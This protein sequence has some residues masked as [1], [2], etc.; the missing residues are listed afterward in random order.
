MRVKLVVISLLTLPLLAVVLVAVSAL[1]ELT[2]AVR[3]GTRQARVEA[4]LVAAMARDEL[5]RS[6]AE[7]QPGSAAARGGAL[8]L[9]EVLVEGP[10]LA[11]SVLSVAVVDTSGRAEAHSQASLAGSMIPPYPD[12]PDTRTFVQSLRLLSDLWQ[13]P[14]V[15]QVVVPLERG[16]RAFG[17][18]RVAISGTFVWDEVRAA[19]GRGLDAALVVITL[20]VIAG[21][22]LA[23]LT[24][25]RMRR[26]RAGVAA[27]RE[28]RFETGLPESA[29]DELGRV[30]RELNLLG[31]QLKW[32]RSR[33]G[34][35]DQ[36]R[37]LAHLGETAA[38]VAHELR[39]HLQTV[40]LEL[41]LLKRA[42]SMPAEEVARHVQRASMGVDSLGGA[43]RGF[44][45]VARVRPLAPRPVRVNE[46][47]RRIR[48]ELRPQAR[49]TGV[50]LELDID[51]AVPEVAADPEVLRQA[52]HNLVR[53]GLQA[54]CD[55]GGTI[56][57]RSSFSGGMI[58]I[59]VADDGPGIP[60]EAQ[61]HAF[62]LFYTTRR[63]GT[64][65][66]LSLVRQA[67][68]MHGGEVSIRSGNGDGT[69]VVLAFPQRPA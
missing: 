69:E 61:V 57:L 32:E 5:A 24:E 34:L 45:K 62:D 50:R 21:I 40:Q 16:G 51:P 2:S 54:L 63:D 14:R 48:E 42:E 20:A 29:A 10:A 66:G 9:H 12:L 59:A 58:R 15:Y 37:V 53:N 49:I 31:A 8:A 43:V 33:S 64:G 11:P 26:L 28:G 56:V 39:N 22:L 41:D 18:V 4:G 25:G 65:V 13:A 67:A 38:G 7:S 17:A 30:G 3:L 1:L 68:E 35:L 46:L 23:R 36:S 6:A 19:A 44:L 60:P 52:M 55:R 27:L 47:L